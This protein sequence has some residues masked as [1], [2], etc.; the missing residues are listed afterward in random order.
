MAS[1]TALPPLVE[2]LA[3]KLAKHV[4]VGNLLL[5][6]TYFLFSQ[7]GLKLAAPPGYATIVWPASGIAL[8]WVLQFG[9][10]LLPGVALGSFASNLLVMAAIR[11]VSPLEQVPW[12]P[13]SVG[14]GAAVQ[15]Y[16]GVVLIR[17]FVAFSPGFDEPADIL[18]ML[19]L[20]GIV[21]TLF[22]A[23]WS[24]SVLHLAGA[25][26]AGYLVQNWLVW[27]VGDSIGV[28]TF[29]PLFLVWGMP[30]PYFNRNRAA[31]VTVVSVLTFALATSAFFLA[32]ALENRD[33]AANFRLTS[34]RAVSQMQQ[35]YAEY[36]QFSRLARG[37]FESS[38]FVSAMEFRRFVDSWLPTHPEVRS[39][40]WAPL[41][42]P[43]LTPD[44]ATAGAAARPDVHRALP[45]TYIEPHLTPMQQPGRDLL[46]EPLY[47]PVILQ[48]LHSGESLLSPTVSGNG[49]GTL[50]LT[51]VNLNVSPERQHGFIVVE[52]DVPWVL[53]RLRQGVFPG[54]Y[55]FQVHQ[56]HHSEV[57]YGAPLSATVKRTAQDM[58][59]HHVSTLQAGG[60]I[61]RVDVWPTKERLASYQNWLTWLVL[62]TG[63]I[64]T[65]LAVIY[66]LAST[67]R[68]QHLERAI[69]LHTR[70]LRERNAELEAARLEADR[71]NE[72]K[73]RF[74]ANM[75]HEI[76]TPMNGVLGMT[77]LL[78][79]TGL[80]AQ[81]QEYLN[82]IRISGRTLLNIIN[83]ILDYSKIEAG[84][85]A[86]ETID[87]DLE[88]LL[89]ECA[90]IFA[91]TA[92]QKRLEFLASI[93]PE[94]PVLI[95]A[96]PLRIRQI[97]INLLSNAFKF[98]RQGHIALRVF[99]REE[100]ARPQLCLEV[101]DTGIGL[102]PAQQAGLF[103]A[104]RQADA[105]T[106]RQFG[107]TGLGLSI[108]KRLAV[109]MGGDIEVQSRYGEGSLFT[110][111]LPFERAGEH[112]C[113]DHRVSLTALNGKRLL[114]VDN[115]PD[116]SRMISEQ[117]ASWGMTADTAHTAGEALNRLRAARESGRPYDYL[118]LDLGLADGGLTLAREIEAQGLAAGARRL[119][120]T[121]LRAHPSPEDLAGAGLDAVLHKP[122]SAT[123][124]RN[125]LLSLVGARTDAAAPLTADAG[126]EALRKVLQGRR[127]LV[128]EDNQVNRLVITGMLRKLDMTA[129]I[130][131]NGLEAVRMQG[132]APGRYDLILMDCEMPELD[133]YE[134]SRRIRDQE[135]SRGLAAIPII[136]LTAHAMP[137]Q[138]VR[139]LEAGMDNC[140]VKPIAFENLKQMLVQQLWPRG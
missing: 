76:R 13:L 4:L 43:T 98:T 109:M 79:D 5:A 99:V 69:A 59:L 57:I 7:L 48:A 87:M 136:A 125:Q 80:S 115:S 33:R 58:G 120:L 30:H 20:G 86:I 2:T 101:S 91:L 37:L 71:A 17:R 63:L 16:I 133:G 103:D 60:Q 112:Y 8:A 85:M 77:E 70:T 131:V 22:N 45:L 95:R 31:I 107:G 67:G 134:A 110:V 74:L 75:S 119:L 126:H 62:V 27:W 36:E 3:G 35:R 44:D 117:A 118:T 47:A 29:T 41:I 1:A 93:A 108:C 55:T 72:A 25:I 49:A 42:G 46:A 84:K 68:R 92:E 66:A 52:L 14:L 21:A 94:T 61:W 10:R 116:F 56:L 81:Q 26:P 104:F 90:S 96:D 130:A 123:V 54:G 23:S 38:D 82:V 122:A 127:V 24:V 105:S 39:V 111:T 89:L 121:P 40:S 139:C 102:T 78:L 11:G 32:M 135:K 129:E 50:L 15:T 124:L 140:L 19:G 53:D 83:D 28:L 12:L 18:R 128:A 6:L 114:L 64:S 137:D 138:Q 106:T 65:S 113:E 88:S 73:S 51:P 132:D 100:H 97:L 34:E 9:N